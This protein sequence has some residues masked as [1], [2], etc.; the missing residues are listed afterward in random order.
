MKTAGVTEMAQ[1]RIKEGREG[2]ARC[3]NRGEGLQLQVN[4][5]EVMTVRGVVSEKLKETEERTKS[6]GVCVR[7]AKWTFFC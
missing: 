5:S 2:Q 6:G 3:F 1:L 7:E 4:G